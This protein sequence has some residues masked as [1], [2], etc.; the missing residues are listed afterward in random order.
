MLGR[1]VEPPPPPPKKA[2]P[3]PAGLVRRGVERRLDDRARPWRQ[4]GPRTLVRE[5]TVPDDA[6]Y[7]R[8]S[9]SYWWVRHRTNQQHQT[10]SSRTA[11]KSERFAVALR[12]RLAERDRLRVAKGGAPRKTWS[13]RSRRTGLV[14]PERSWMSPCDQV[15]RAHVLGLFASIEGPWLKAAL[16][17]ALPLRGDGSLKAQLAD[18]LFGDAETAFA[19]DED[20]RGKNGKDGGVYGKQLGEELRKG[21]WRT[22]SRYSTS[23]TRRDCPTRS[24]Q[25]SRLFSAAESGHRGGPRTF[26][27]D[28]DAATGAS[29][30]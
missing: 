30:W 6:S 16:D 23:S 29:F 11:Q 1:C 8:G 15:L 13:R 27:S 28:V 22:S 24:P 25:H 17:A 4:G 12:G 5:T 19:R 9:T 14:L 18:H 20:N 2:T 10:R 7:E 21:A 3:R 26:S